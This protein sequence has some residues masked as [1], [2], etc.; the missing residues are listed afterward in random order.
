MFYMRIQGGVD[1]WI[2]P[3]CNSIRVERY[4]S[5]VPIHFFWSFGVDFYFPWSV[6]CIEK[7]ALK[8]IHGGFY[9][10]ETLSS[11]EWSEDES[12]LL[13]VADLTPK[14][15]PT[16]KRGERLCMEERLG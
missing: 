12:L 4:C 1:A 2:C 13:Y 15:E 10:D 11:F 3:K 7:Y 6:H 16:T 8:D 14:E 5:C 9:A